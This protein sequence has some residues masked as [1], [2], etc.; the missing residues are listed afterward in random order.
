MHLHLGFKLLADLVEQVGERGV[1][2]GFLHGCA[3]RANGPELLKVCLQWMHGRTLSY[4][5]AQSEPDLRRI[6]QP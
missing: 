5:T 1:V 2:R 4:T 6:G 3:R